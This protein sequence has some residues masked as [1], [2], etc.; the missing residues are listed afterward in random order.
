[1]ERNLTH[2][3][4]FAALTMGLFVMPSA[5]LTVGV[6]ISATSLG[7]MLCGTVLGSVRGGL[8]ALLFVFLV[9]ANVPALFGAVGGLG[10]FVGPR[11]GFLIGFPFAAFVTG[12]IMERWN[13][14][15]GLVALSASL[16]GG[17]AVLYTFGV[18]VMSVM[19]A[20]EKID[21]MFKEI[22]TYL[23]IPLPVALSAFYVPGDLI[24][25]V[26]A[27]LVTQAIAQARPGALL[28]RG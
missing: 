19:L 26:L 12:F 13:G 10:I 14:R 28:S 8:A 5:M 7:I 22:P 23:S 17:I 27:A 24:K 25:A 6:P 1:M 18:P 9:A 4:L 11:A 21:A 20:Q 15:I 16:I 3:A 2:I